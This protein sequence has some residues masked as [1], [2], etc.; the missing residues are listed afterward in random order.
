MSDNKIKSREET[1]REIVQQMAN[2][3]E[4]NENLMKK[5][6]NDKESTDLL[7]KIDKMWKVLKK[8]IKDKPEFMDYEDKKNYRT[9]AL[10]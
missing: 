6:E 8:L 9:F 1:D 7:N 2:S 3:S 4:Q 5:L 10:I